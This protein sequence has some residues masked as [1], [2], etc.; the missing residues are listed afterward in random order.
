MEDKKTELIV[1]LLE[2]LQEI[3]L[4]DDKQYQGEEGKE[5]ILGYITQEA[6]GKCQK[7]CQCEKKV[8]GCDCGCGEKPQETKCDHS[9]KY[10]CGCSKKEGNKCNKKPFQVEFD[11]PADSCVDTVTIA[12]DGIKEFCICGINW[13]IAE[14]VVYLKYKDYCGVVREDCQHTS[15]AFATCEKDYK[16][17]TISLPNCPQVKTHCGTV[18]VCGTAEICYFSC[19]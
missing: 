2:E 19:C 13:V 9:P 3:A 17:Y 4:I 16:K 14:I 12:R 8:C 15:V 7:K 6:K 1:K 5:D 18:R 11:I 10:S